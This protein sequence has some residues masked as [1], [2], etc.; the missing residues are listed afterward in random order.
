MTVPYAEVI[1]DPVAHSKSPLIHKFWLGKLGLDY[2][3]RATRVAAD[4]LPAF[5]ERRLVDPSWC[6][7]NVTMPHKIA[8]AALVEELLPPARRIGAVNCIIRGGG[9]PARLV[10]RNTDVSGFLEPLRRYV[11]ADPGCC[12]AD[13]VGTGGAALAVTV[14]LDGAGF[15][16]ASYGRTWQKAV[17]LRHALGLEEDDLAG[18]LDCLAT[19]APS[20]APSG[21]ILE[22]R[23]VSLFVNA[24]PLGMAGYPPL[25]IDPSRWSRETL[26]YDLV[27]DPVETPLLAMARHAGLPTIDGLS[28]LIGQAAAAFELFFAEPASREHDDEL[29]GLLMR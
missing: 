15:V 10:G 11:P 28:M 18:G 2:D 9:K 26:V 23:E 7:C 20:C 1:G 13:V 29:R 16:V 17:A 3:Y 6:G 4:E 27:Y 24:T 5:L 21:T 12:F 14:A 22:S 25:P 8:A 19:E